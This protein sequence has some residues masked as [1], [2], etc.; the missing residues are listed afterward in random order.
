[1]GRMNLGTLLAAPSPLLNTALALAVGLLAWFLSRLVLRPDEKRLARVGLW[2]LIAYGV[3][4]GV[5]L[6]FKL[7]PSGRKLVD[8]ISLFFL[9]AS[10]GRSVFLLVTRLLM[11]R[12]LGYRIPRIV[13]DLTQGGIFIGVALLALQVAG[14]NATSLLATSAVLT[15]VLG[16]SLQETLGNLF[17]GLAIQGEQPFQVGDWVQFDQSPDRAGRVIEINWRATTI[18]TAD[19]VLITVP[20]GVLARAPITNFNRPQTYAR[21][22][23]LIDT[24]F[25]APAALRE[26]LEKATAQVDGVL[27]TPAPSAVIAEVTD[28]SVR[29]RVRFFINDHPR[30]DEISGSVLSNILHVLDRLGLEVPMQRRRVEWQRAVRAEAESSPQVA[31]R[32]V[33]DRIDL[34]RPLSDDARTVLAELS[35]VWRYARGE[36]VVRAGEAG[37]ELFIVVSGNVKVQIQQRGVPIE[38]AQLGP[39]EFFGE[40]SLLTGEPRA[41]T[42][43]ATEE[44]EVVVVDHGAF[45]AAIERDPAVLAQISQELARRQA[46][47]SERLASGGSAYPAETAPLLLARIRRFFGVPQ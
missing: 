27:E 47:L 7:A 16:L 43:I 35:K 33:I 22:H 38:V 28:F 10:L 29:Y 6:A 26:L 42:V 3:L 21:R 4:H 19:R 34:L 37:H 12:G 36:S 32:R 25:G 2:L 18:E 31:R 8:A 23:V 15:A 1:M 17:A 41:A 45:Q 30:R 39:G 46:E 20:N 24:P 44:T 5:S 9:L 11:M 40:M 14:V 13:Q